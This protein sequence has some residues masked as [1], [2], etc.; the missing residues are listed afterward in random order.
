M[1]S[2]RL[3][4]CSFRTVLSSSLEAG[5]DWEREWQ[6]SSVNSG[7]RSQLQQGTYTKKMLKL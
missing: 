2:M 4:C 6:K 1:S 3:I 5:L 7:Q